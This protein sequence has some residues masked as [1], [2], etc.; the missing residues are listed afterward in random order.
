MIKRWDNA[1]HYP[2]ISSFPDHLHDGSEQTVIP[3]APISA[4]DALEF[5]LGKVYESTEHSPN[6]ESG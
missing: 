2:Q 6:K 3:H 4:L 1:P 5:I